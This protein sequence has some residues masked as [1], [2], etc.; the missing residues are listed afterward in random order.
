MV[1]ICSSMSRNWTILLA[2]DSHKGVFSE[3]VLAWEAD[4]TDISFDTVR[5]IAT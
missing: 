1:S 3:I 5:G 4:I 2:L